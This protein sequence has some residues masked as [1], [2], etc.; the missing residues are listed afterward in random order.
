MERSAEPAEYVETLV[1]VV[2]VVQVVQP[3][4]APAGAVAMAQ[5]SFLRRR[6]EMLLNGE[7]PRPLR[8][9]HACALFV[10]AAACCLPLAAL[11][12]RPGLP[13]A[14]ATGTASLRLSASFS[15]CSAFNSS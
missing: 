14:M 2:R 9:S 7:A 11:Q 3:P 1:K 8:R 10:L 6:I 15:A 13:L 5:K 12:L 4:P